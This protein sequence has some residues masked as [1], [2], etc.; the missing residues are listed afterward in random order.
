MSR[1]VR[2]NEPHKVPQPVSN[3]GKARRYNPRP[4]ILGKMIIQAQIIPIR[5]HLKPLM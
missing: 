2:L 1:S 3:P 5:R 4:E